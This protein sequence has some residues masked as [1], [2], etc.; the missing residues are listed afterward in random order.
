MATSEDNKLAIDKCSASDRPKKPF[1]LHALATAAA[2]WPSQ[3]V[4]VASSLW[5]RLRRGWRRTTPCES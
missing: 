3:A 4:W 1:L 2:A 5:K